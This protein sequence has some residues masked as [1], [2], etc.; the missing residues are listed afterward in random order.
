MSEHK[1]LEDFDA[2][3]ILP[4]AMAV[5]RIVRLPV[6]ARSGQKNGVRI[7]E[8]NLISDDYTGPV[9]EESIKLNSLLKTVPHTGPYKG[10][11]V[12][13]AP[14]QNENNEAVGAI[15]I[16]DFTGIFDLATLMEHQSGIMK[17]V[18]GKDPCPLPKEL[19]SSKR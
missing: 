14:I 17:Q 4:F 8:G 1:L 10:V 7:E 19:T 5:H 15:G 16:V 3:D 12:I 2:E 18:C 6:T 9:L 11:P 13:V